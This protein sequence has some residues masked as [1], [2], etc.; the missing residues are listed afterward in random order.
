MKNDLLGRRHVL[1][2]EL[3][4]R[5]KQKKLLSVTEYLETIRRL[6]NY[7]MSHVHFNAAKILKKI[8]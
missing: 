5:L 3:F 8:E 4:G 7:Y 1:R 2:I 6:S